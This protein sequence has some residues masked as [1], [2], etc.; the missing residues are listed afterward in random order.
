MIDVAVMGLDSINEYSMVTFSISIENECNYS[1]LNSDL[2]F[3]PLFLQTYAADIFFCQTWKDH[4]LRIPE[5][6][7]SDYQ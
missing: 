3:T 2:S 7:T 5:N 4:R 1:S 6:M